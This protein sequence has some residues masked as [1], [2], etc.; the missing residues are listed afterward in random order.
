MKFRVL[1]DDNF[2]YMDESER[3][4]AGVFDTLEEAIIACEKIVDKSLRH[5]YPQF[6]STP[7]RLYDDY[8]DFGDDPFIRSEPFDPDFHFSAWNYAKRRSADIVAEFAG[9]G[10]A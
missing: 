6:P 7:E 10:Y 3:I 5:L 4:A 9:R 8:Q 2:H 1:V